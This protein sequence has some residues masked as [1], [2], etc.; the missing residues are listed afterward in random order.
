[1]GIAGGE[2]WTVETRGRCPEII[3]INLPRR[4]TTPEAPGGIRKKVV[5]KG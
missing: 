1:M 3:L 5:P 2:K 4:L